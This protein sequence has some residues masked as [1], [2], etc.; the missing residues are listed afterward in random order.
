VHAALVTL[1]VDPDQ[2]PAAAEA[3]M[4]DILPGVRSAAGFVVGYWLEPADGQGFSMVLFESEEQAREA[5]PPLS[6]LGCARDRHHRSRVSASSSDR[7]NPSKESR[8]Q[9]HKGA[10]GW[11]RPRSVMD[12]AR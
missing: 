9:L 10:R 6:N 5:A 4:S 8:T 11:T 7:L 12:A 1:T 3:L 2:A